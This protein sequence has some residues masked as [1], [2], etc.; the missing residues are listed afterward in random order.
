MNQVHEY[1]GYWWLPSNPKIK[2]AGILKYIP[3]ESII[4]ELIGSFSH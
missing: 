3:S 2:I 1:K 4:L